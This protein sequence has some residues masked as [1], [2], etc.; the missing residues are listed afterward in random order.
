MPGTLYVVATP[1]GN[2][3]DVSLR[4]IKV[5]SGVG[6]IAAEDTRKTRILLDRYRGLSEYAGSDGFY[7]TFDWQT[8]D[9]GCHYLKIC[10][11]KHTL[12]HTNF[13]GKHSIYKLWYRLPQEEK[14]LGITL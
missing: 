10:L 12:H 1:I 14:N 6:L 2:L 3:E 9:C 5:L 11:L 8:I 13:F 4:A 7:R